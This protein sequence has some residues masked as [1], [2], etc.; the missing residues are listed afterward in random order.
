MIQNEIPTLEG[1]ALDKAVHEMRGKSP[2]WE[3]VIYNSDESG[4][5]G[6]T[7]SAGPWFTPMELRDWLEDQQNQGRLQNHHIKTK[8]YYP[9]YSHDIAQAW[10]LIEAIHGKRQFAV[11]SFIDSYQCD[12]MDPYE[13]WHIE[14]AETAPI[15]ICRAYLKMMAVEEVYEQQAGNP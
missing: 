7:N 2:R 5:V 1:K 6:A 14:E 15:A 8:P 10:E 13:I 9:P 12:W 4:I 11:W 3:A